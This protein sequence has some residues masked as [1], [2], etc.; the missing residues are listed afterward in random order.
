MLVLEHSGGDEPSPCTLNHGSPAA[1][2]GAD[3]HQES[4]GEPWE[5]GLGLGGHSMVVVDRK[6]RS[7]LGEGPH[8]GR[9]LGGTL[10]MGRGT[11]NILLVVVVVRSEAADMEGGLLLVQSD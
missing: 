7:G 5:V 9:S 2:P 6:C 8:L 4:L 10:L 1:A 11:R 3:L